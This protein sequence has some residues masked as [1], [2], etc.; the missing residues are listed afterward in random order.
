MN[1]LLQIALSAAIG[2]LVAAPT[3]FIVAGFAWGANKRHED[4]D[5]DIKTITIESVA[6]ARAIRDAINQ[7]LREHDEGSAAADNDAGPGHY[8]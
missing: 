7:I 1:T 4:D 8:L 6:E 2:G 3:G 5:S